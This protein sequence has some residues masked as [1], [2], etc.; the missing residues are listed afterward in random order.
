MLPF[1]VRFINLSVLSCVGPHGVRDCCGATVFVTFEFNFRP[2]SGRFLASGSGNLFYSNENSN[3]WRKYF[4]SKTTKKTKGAA[5]WEWRLFAKSF[6]KPG[7]R[8]AN[9]S[10]MVIKFLLAGMKAR[11]VIQGGRT[12][13]LPPLPSRAQLRVINGGGVVSRTRKR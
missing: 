3:L 8:D 5:T 2:G 6:K 13:W 11:E 1:F 10:E 9:V 4:L 7:V 12:Y